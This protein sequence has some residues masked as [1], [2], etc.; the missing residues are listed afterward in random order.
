MQ[1]VHIAIRRCL[2]LVV[3]VGF[4]ASRDFLCSLIGLSY[5][6]SLHGLHILLTY[7]SCRVSSPLSSRLVFFFTFSTSDSIY[8]RM[9]S[10]VWTNTPSANSERRSMWFLEPSLRTLEV[11]PGSDSSLCCKRGY[12]IAVAFCGVG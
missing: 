10:K 5:P 8:T 7:V 4:C 1:E 2:F 6:E 9:R 12:V 3:C 11:G